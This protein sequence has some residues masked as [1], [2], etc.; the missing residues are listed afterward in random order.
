MPIPDTSKCIHTLIVIP[1]AHAE[2]A[3]VV[4]LLMIGIRTLRTVKT[5]QLDERIPAAA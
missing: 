4:C 2:I 3:M 5:A 1:T